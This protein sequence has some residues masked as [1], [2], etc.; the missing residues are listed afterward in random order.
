[1][2]AVLALGAQWPASAC[3]NL[4]PVERL[5]PDAPA[6]V[7]SSGIDEPRQS[8]LRDADG[9]AAIWQR[10]YGRSRPVP[11]VPFVDFER[12]MVVV[13][14]LGRQQSGGYAMRVDRAILEGATTVIVVH[15]ES[16]GEG[17]IV[18]NALT[19]PVDIAKLPLLPDPVEFRFEASSRNCN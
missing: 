13:V 19:S 15:T 11:S 3:G 1:L 14:A 10:I 8:V 17:C 18:T 2:F 9:W 5:R 4:V 6:Y 7:Q 12:E 16:P